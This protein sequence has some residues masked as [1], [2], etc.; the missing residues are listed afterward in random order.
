MQ[1]NAFSTTLIAATLINGFLAYFTWKRRPVRGST[2]FFMLLLAVSQ[3]SFFA[4][5]EAAAETVFYKTL[6]SVL[7]YPGI[8]ALPLLFLIFSCRYAKADNWLSKRNIIILSIIPFLTVVFAATN[9]LHGLIWSKITLAQNELAGIYGVYFHG[10]W[11]WINISYS[12]L[13]LIIALF[14][15]MLSMYKYRRIYNIQSRILIFSATVPIIANIVYAFSPKTIVGFDITP[16]FFTV[17]GLLLFLAFFYY[18]LFDFSPVAL[19][20]IIES[21]NDG[22]VLFDVQNR[23]VE[24]NA[25][26]SEILGME[27]IK[28]G[29]EK[30]ILYSR[31]PELNRLTELK[32]NIKKIELSVI[33]NKKKKYLH[34]ISSAL[35]ERNKK[36]IIGD[37]LIL[38]DITSEK[39]YENKISE[40]RDLLS[41][42]IDFL[43]D[44][45]LAIDINGKT[46][47]WNKALE[48]LSGIKKDD[49]IKKGDSLYSLPFY[50]QSKPVLLDLL[51]NKDF[52]LEK[53]YDNIQHS[54]DKI[55]AELHIRNNGQNYYFWSVASFL[56][57][58]KGE[59]LGAIE[60]I[61]DITDRKL[62][63]ERLKHL[64]FHDSMTSLYNRT[65]FEEELK[66]M[67]SIRML[68][69]SII[70]L[71]LNGLKLVN[72][73]FGHESGDEL[74]K[75]A[76]KI[77]NNCCRQ[78][79]VIA[80]WG[81]D[82]F[83]V[84]LPET[85]SE[86]CSQ[87]LNRIKDAC[88]STTDLKIPVSIAMGFATK[89]EIE[90]DINDVIKK[91]ED[92]M[93]KNKMLNAK[94]V[95]SQIVK[96]LTNALYEKNIETVNHSERV[97]KLAEK[98]GKKLM[99]AEDRMDDL[100]LHASL[101]DIGKVA[102]SADLINKGEK[103]TEKEW[104][105][106]KKHSEAGYRIASSS[107]LL[108]PIAE[109]ILAHHEWWNGTGYP[110]GLKGE[111]IPIISRIV[112]I[113]D[114]Y[115]IMI[116]G[117][118]YKEPK[119]KDEAIIELKKFAGIQFDPELIKHF[120]EII[121]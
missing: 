21:L 42:I 16:V 96:S 104:D 79:D 14:T 28:I 31:L 65:F 27:K 116:S 110:R 108:S 15:L 67:D 106:V 100:L 64:S 85:T 18:K 4:I 97:I 82:E 73:A 92:K 86:H 29:T 93:Y 63:E 87:V 95:Q 43:P 34:I 61:R 32:G 39:N 91:A 119:S 19:E 70:M 75:N 62:A 7:T 35:Y 84:M 80:R 2:E 10:V 37:I 45:T 74:L 78:T 71:D 59:V 58:S 72:D 9:N 49:V 11:F 26:A 52:K 24:S 60:S 69:I 22:I 51:L 30:A 88:N 48:K 89:E 8:C 57:G 47:A 117:R 36:N 6:F 102:L 121:R 46:I 13:I 109:Y 77:I 20:T 1:L 3:W 115:D 81:G 107:T 112:S 83:I 25:K 120:V 113:A 23:V 41:D 50:G 111:E 118:P 103:L 56:Y 44:P 33:K 40:T 114:A 66:R 90:E 12:Y 54:D 101:H 38:R 53:Y 98:M 76:A 94:S 55:K 99:F 5:F 68:P 105:A 17:S